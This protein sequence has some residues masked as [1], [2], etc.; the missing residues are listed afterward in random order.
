[1][2]QQIVEGVK[3]RGNKLPDKTRPLSE[4]PTRSPGVEIV[5]DGRR[6]DLTGVATL[7]DR[8][9]ALQVFASRRRPFLEEAVTQCHERGAKEHADNTEG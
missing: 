7:S 5:F 2:F 4:A 8:I 9:A 6:L 1:M 3:L